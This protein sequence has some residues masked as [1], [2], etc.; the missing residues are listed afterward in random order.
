[1]RSLFLIFFFLAIPL[2]AS[3]VQVPTPVEPQANVVQENAHDGDKDKKSD[4]AL[5]VVKDNSQ[6]E[7][8]GTKKT[9][10]AEDT[11]AKRAKE[12]K[13]EPAQTDRSIKEVNVNKE[14]AENR[15]SV[16]ADVH[17]QESHES[18]NNNN[19]HQF[20]NL[21]ASQ[22]VLFESIAPPPTRIELSGVFNS[23]DEF[24]GVTPEF[25]IISAGKKD[26]IKPELDG[27]TLVLNWLSVG[28][29]EITLQVKNPETGAIAYNKLTAESW[30]PNYWSMFLTVIG[31]LGVFLLGM[32]YLSDGLQMM[33]GAGLRRMI[34]AV[35]ENRLMAVGVGLFTTM[36]IQSSSVT[37]VMV[38]GFINS[39][40]MTLAQGIGVIMGANI[41]TTFTAW[42]LVLDIG[43]YG[44]PLLG[45]SAL[46]Y[47]FSKNDKMR[48]VAMSFMGLGFVFFGLELMQ[49]GFSFLRELQSFTEWMNSFTADNYWGVL[50]CA[51]IGCI[52]TLIVQSSSATLAITISLA[53]IGV[54]NFETAGALV[55]G[56]NIGTTITAVLA[57]IGA[58]A[59]ARRAAYF[60][61]LFNLIGVLWVTAIFLPVLCPFIR[62]WLVG[63]NPET[64]VIENVKLG[65]AYTHTLF[66]VTNTVVFFPF[67]GKIANLLV[68]FISDKNGKDKKSSL[69]GLNIWL[70]E[71]SAIAVERSRVEVLRM[72]SGCVDLSDWVEKLRDSEVP[73]EELIDQSFRQEEVLDSLQDELI[74]FI[75]DLI[76]NSNITHDTAEIARGQLRMADELESI[77]DYLIV[78][79]KSDLKLR[80]SNLAI[81]EPIMSQIAELHKHTK[82]YIAMIHRYYA[83][84]KD[85]QELMTE[86]HSQGRSI[87][88]RAKNIRDQFLRTMTEEKVDPQVIM[89]I[90]TQLNAYR[91]VREHSQ[92]VAEAIVGVK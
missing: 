82:E 25:S 35:T 70:L 16:P 28:K 83:E 34:A 72:S 47:L 49:K 21:I 44:L 61:V 56:E 59:N 91:R 38:V 40:I 67:A 31:G 52:L 63:I 48:F 68:K 33:A 27:S 69:T 86:V 9:E 89:A 23:L 20:Y 39:Q 17:S 12:N 3:D 37:T 79:L 65:I 66:N 62:Y 74:E 19:K 46:F 76:S 29:S 81:P 77:S 7:T 84:R 18:T 15:D 57:S 75:A 64:G 90:N 6:D 42:I 51:M 50:K 4:D 36:L 11:S 30:T 55:L 71:S 87:T 10:D 32:K 43:K 14:Q 88:A 2:L 8:E 85:G 80:R 53:S 73:S 5:G 13:V 24:K 92:N 54:I 60:H 41:G 1:M 22:R 58:S 26:I 45:V 78:I